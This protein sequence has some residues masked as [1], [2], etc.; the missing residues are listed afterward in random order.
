MF[1]KELVTPEYFVEYE[2]ITAPRYSPLHGSVSVCFKGG[3]EEVS[4][5]VIVYACDCDVI[6]VELRL[7]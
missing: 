7:S 6:V 5:K 3:K 4:W 2:Y 1:E